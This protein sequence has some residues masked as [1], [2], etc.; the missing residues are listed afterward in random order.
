MISTVVTL[1]ALKLFSPHV[2]APVNVPLKLLSVL[3]WI[4]LLGA[5]RFIHFALAEIVSRHSHALRPKRL[6]AFNLPK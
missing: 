1:S 4:S 5:A 2:N 6:E 3:N